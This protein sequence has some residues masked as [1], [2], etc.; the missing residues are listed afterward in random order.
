LV[1]AS[2]CGKLETADVLQLLFWL[3]GLL[4]LNLNR[5]RKRVKSNEEL[6]SEIMQFVALAG[7]PEG[8]VPSMKE[9]SA[10]G[11]FRFPNSKIADF[12]KFLAV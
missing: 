1:F 9:L 7:L 6:R 11:R 4:E 2:I 3:I 10:H 8:H 12:V 5:V